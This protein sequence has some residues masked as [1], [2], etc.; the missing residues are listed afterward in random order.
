VRQDRGLEPD[1]RTTT[2]RAAIA[3]LAAVA[4]GCRSSK[5]SGAPEPTGR[6]HELGFAS[7][8]AS[9][10]GQCALVDV[11]PSAEELPI[12]VAL[13]GRGEAGR[14]LLHGARG[15]RDDYRI[16]RIRERLERNDLQSDDVDGW[17]SAARLAAIRASLSAV[18]YRGVT[19]AC[20]Y[21]PVPAGRG[22]D[23]P[24]GFGAFVVERLLPELAQLRGGRA[25]SAESTGIDGI[26][27]GGRIALFVGWSHPRHF[28][29]VGAMQPAIEVAEAP[30]LARLARE[31][32]RVR[33]Q[34]LRLA[35]STDDPF[36]EATTML[37]KALEAEG[38][39]HDLVVTDGPHDYAWNRGPGA[40]ELLVFHE[41]VLRGLPAPAA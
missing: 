34:H 37:S 14:G 2:R 10:M 7:D 11:P 31:A 25:P 18:P 16:D 21:T 40:A 30:A 32:Q 8:G 6:W 35:S 9:P 33:R 23:E 5:R 26:S 4:F 41:R 15:Y 19:L 17:L 3:G 1:T 13:H 12:V 36:L 28:S 29:A 22:Q 38:V 20:P 27:M 24:K 39:E